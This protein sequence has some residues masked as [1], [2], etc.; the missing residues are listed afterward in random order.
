MRKDHVVNV[1]GSGIA[2]AGMVGLLGACNDGASTATERS[3]QSS[4]VRQ[5]LADLD[6]HYPELRGQTLKSSQALPFVIPTEIFNFTNE[7]IDFEA[8]TALYKFYEA[9][10]FKVEFT[11]G[12]EANGE[13]LEL[14][15]SQRVSQHRVLA[16]VPAN[17]RRPDWSDLHIDTAK[18]F[19]ATRIQH[20]GNTISYVQDASV[21][22]LGEQLEV[23]RKEL[24][25][26][27]AVEACHQTLMGR[28]LK[29]DVLLADAK[30]ILF[31]QELWCNSFG[32]AVGAKILGLSY[33]EY[34]AM[35]LQQTV[36]VEGL[37]DDYPLLPI[38]EVSYDSLPSFSPIVLS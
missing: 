25:V 5:G 12:I 2:L 17:A 4:G 7:K 20:D 19:A 1:V 15:Y 36:T 26:G 37:I 11:N 13:K 30:H 10:G 38:K 9:R 3:S 27:L 35:A 24:T 23:T 29:D 33:A 34:F 18:H 6:L 31:G 8:I 28:L 22:Q 32:F 21:S 14:A 16:F